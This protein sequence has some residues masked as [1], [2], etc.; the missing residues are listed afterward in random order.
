MSKAMKLITASVMGI[1]LIPS[2]ANAKLSMSNPGAN[3]V[4]SAMAPIAGDVYITP[5]YWATCW[6]NVTGTEFIGS[7]LKT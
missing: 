1:L 3:W 7:A 4:D 5:T 6:K 2:L